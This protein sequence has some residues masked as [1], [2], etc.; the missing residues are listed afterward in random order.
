MDREHHGQQQVEGGEVDD[1]PQHHV[2]DE[3]NAGEDAPLLPGPTSQSR[4]RSQNSTWRRSVI[5]RFQSFQVE[6]K[7]TR[8]WPS[9]IALISLCFLV[10]LIIILGFIAPRAMREYA[11]EAATFEPTT[12]S[13]QNLTS[14]GVIARI[15]GDFY[16]DASQ[17]KRK[18]VRGF[19]RFGT[20]IAREVHSGWTTVEVHASDFDNI[21]LGSANVGPITVNV[22]NQERTPL[23]FSIEINSGDSDG[24]KKIANKWA[25]GGLKELKMV[26]KANV[27]IKSGIFSFGH[28]LI[29]QTLTFHKL[30]TLPAYSIDKMIFEDAGLP[31]DNSGLAIN[32]TLVVKND[33]PVNVDVPAMAFEVYSPNCDTEMPVI[34]IGR[35]TSQML[36]VSAFQDVIVDLYGLVQNLPEGFTK[37]CPGGSS[38]PLDRM[39]EAFFRG[40]ESKVFIKGSS[41]HVDDV[42]KWISDLV[43]SILL[44]ILIPTQ[45]FAAPTVDNLTL[46]NV[47]IDLPN[48]FA[49]DGSPE[50]NPAV[51]ATLNAT[52]L[53]PSQINTSLAVQQLKADADVFYKGSKLGKLDLKNW[54]SARSSQS[55]HESPDDLNYLQVE[56]DIHRAPINITDDGTF[57]QILQALLFGEKDVMLDIKASV[58]V[59]LI[60]AVGQVTVKGLPAEGRV[61]VK[62][63]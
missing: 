21:L 60:T 43:S 45:G 33:Y 57:D 24:I 7:P 34:P 19:G 13:I 23:D 40:E 6:T 20:W 62:R 54:Q 46:D 55:S 48:P 26:G 56:C 59:R 42:P 29:I 30:G 16:M 51:S 36:H 9:L 4:N 31:E 53:I 41:A 1:I 14:R 2:N 28:Q 63:S 27:P 35:V 32:A 8:R 12:L 11:M 50:S 3:D 22:R 38:S 5:S 15:Q 58:D 25:A 37:A 17:V 47:Q 44:P 39:M 49:K 10:I 61:P 18:S 52:I